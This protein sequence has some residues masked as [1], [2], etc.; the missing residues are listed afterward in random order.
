MIESAVE[1]TLGGDGELASLADWGAKYVGAV[2]RIAGI[3]HL[4]EHGA[5]TG[6]REAVEAHTIQ[7]A[8]EI[9]K[10]FKASAI[11]AFT[12]MATDRGTTDATYLL[13][14]IGRL[15]HEEVSVRDLF[16]ACSRSRFKTVNDLM[17]AIERLIDHGYVCPLP[18]PKPTGG[19]PAS[20]RFKVHKTV[21]EAAQGA[22]SGR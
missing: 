6:P 10:Y 12:E 3:L 22:E 18:P 16:T 11:K 17:P 1:P 19:R 14:R 4:A 7:A 9:G 5:D 2:A 21:A 13:D 8:W 15:A 20:P